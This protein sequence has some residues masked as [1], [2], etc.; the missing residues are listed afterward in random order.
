MYRIIISGIIFFLCYSVSAQKINN[1]A[2]LAKLNKFSFMAEIAEKF[3]PTQPYSE[4]YADFIKEKLKSENPQVDE[5]ILTALSKMVVKPTNEM[6][7]LDIDLQSEDILIQYY[8]AL[9]FMAGKQNTIAA[10]LLSKCLKKAPASGYTRFFI[11]QSLNKAQNNRKTRKQA[12]DVF[13]KLILSHGVTSKNAKVLYKLTY[14]LGKPFF[15]KLAEKVKNAEHVDEWYKLILQGHAGIMLAWNSRGSGWSSTV[16]KEGW[17]GFHANLQNAEKYLTEAWKINPDFPEAPALMITVSMGNSSVDNRIEWFKRAIEA[18]FDYHFAYRSINNAIAP[19]WGGS[20][21]LLLDLAVACLK[22]GRNDTNVPEYGI[23]ILLNLAGEISDYRWQLAFL[24]R[25]VRKNLLQWAG[26]KVHAAKSEDEKNEALTLRALVDVY[27]LNYQHANEI[28]EKLTPDV[29]DE[30]IEKLRKKRAVPVPA[31]TNPGTLIKMFTGK[32]GQELSD[33]Q[34]SFLYGKK[35]DARLR[36]FTLIRSGKL[37]KE[38]KFFAIDF[39]AKTEIKKSAY[40]YKY[41]GGSALH[42]AIYYK[43]KVT[44]IKRLLKLGI[45]HKLVTPK[46]QRPALITAARSK[47]PIELIDA[48]KE[49]GADLNQQDK[50]GWTA[51]EHSIYMD[52]LPFTKRL[53]ELG[54]NINTTSNNNP[55]LLKALLLKRDKTVKMLL[56]AGA[57]VNIRVSFNNC[58]LLMRALSKN[59]DLVRLK[60]ILKNNINLELRGNRN[61]TAI[62]YAVCYHRNPEATKL[63]IEKGANVNIRDRDGDTPLI[64]AAAWSKTPGK[65]TIL[66][67]AGARINDKNKSGRTPLIM[68]AV[69]RR[70]LKEI[71]ILVEHGAKLNE[72]DNSGHTA[73]DWAVKKKNKLATEYLSKHG[74]LPASKIKL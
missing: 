13:E 55:L 1:N 73:Y 48:F 23:K 68:A 8:N 50:Y 25:R 39:F 5:K 53:I 63:L 71:K 20:N 28:L 30:E 60:E 9:S 22:Y 3:H 38:E 21:K 40:S 59:I 61:W 57:D 7:S 51:L 11:L 35:A 18:Q 44:F 62:G 69:S 32:H 15:I 36:L 4:L 46:N 49:A 10:K 27:T 72:I 47:A 65:I 54:A 16:T 45:N 24:Q 34:K 56:E 6:I 2:M 66:L 19:K 58:T 14:D 26:D 41:F 12:Q 31:W 42:V 33:I 52:N 17:K 29:F 64:A 74:A 70:S 67:K 37:T 43:S